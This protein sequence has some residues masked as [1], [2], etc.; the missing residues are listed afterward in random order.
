MSDAAGGFD[1][2]V[3]CPDCDS[4]H[5]IPGRVIE[6]SSSDGGATGVR[7]APDWLRGWR[8][9]TVEPRGEGVMHACITCGLLWGRVARLELRELLITKGDEATRTWVEAMPKTSRGVTPGTRPAAP[10]PE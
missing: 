3:R 7:F 4:P 2:H 6:A 10:E 8:A 1:V 5:V 9:S